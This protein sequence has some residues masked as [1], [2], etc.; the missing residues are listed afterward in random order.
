M[1]ARVFV[2]FFLLASILGGGPSNSAIWQIGRAEDVRGLES[3]FISL[4]SSFF[5]C[6]L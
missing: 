3:L 2:V 1:L 6:V 4:S 5:W